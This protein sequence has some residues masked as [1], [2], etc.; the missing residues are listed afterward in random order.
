MNF[1]KILIVIFSLVFSWCFILR[2]ALEGVEA[3]K[4]TCLTGLSW[5]SHCRIWCEETQRQTKHNH[6]APHVGAVSSFVVFYGSTRKHTQLWYQQKPHQPGHMAQTKA[7]QLRNCVA[8]QVKFFWAKDPK[9][10]LSCRRHARPPSDPSIW[11]QPQQPQ[12]YHAKE[13]KCCDAQKP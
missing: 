13:C 9:A 11:A 2:I 7:I 1:F 10:D 4:Q 5:R 6:K 12:T 3:R 8:K